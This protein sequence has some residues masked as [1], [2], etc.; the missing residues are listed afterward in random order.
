MASG[1]RNAVLTGLVVDA[2]RTAVRDAYERGEPVD[3]RIRSEH[4]TYDWVRLAPGSS[5]RWDWSIFECAA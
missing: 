3:F 4:G 2:A 5:P 1:D